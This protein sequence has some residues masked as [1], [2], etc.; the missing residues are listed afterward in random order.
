MS[1]ETWRARA[2]STGGIAVRLY[3]PTRKQLL[4]LSRAAANS[5]YCPY[6]KFHVGAA[7]LANG[8]FYTGSNI[9]NASY[10]LTICAERSAI[11]RAIVSGEKQI[12][13]IAVSC[14]DADP[15]A[16]A[17]YRMPCGA[18]RQVIA[19]FA[20]SELIVLVDG[21][22]DFAV[23]DLL[24]SPFLLSSAADRPS[25]PSIPSELVSKNPKPRLCV[26]ID[27][28]IADSDPL[29]R[30]IITEVTKG[31]VQLEYGDVKNFNYW[32]CSDRNA[33]QLDRSDWDKVHTIFSERV[34]DVEP[35]PKA[36]PALRRLGEVF[37][38]HLVTSRKYAAR[39]GTVQWLSDNGFPEN[40]RLHFLEWREKHLALG[41]FFA[42]VEDEL[43]QAVSFAHAGIHSFLY[44]HPWNASLEADSLLHRLPSWDEIQNQLLAMASE[45][46]R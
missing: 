13:A 41:R 32:Q 1:L 29:M 45:I 16:A 26:D 24:P 21:V 39:E 2:R 15:T 12:D 35:Y 7:V 31:R 11:F 19:E 14:P 3:A 23:G 17:T 25:V 5:A 18:C 30:R 27:N 9:E 28:V 6:S 38:I 8:Q 20:S 46:G 37:D 36:Q 43:E 4:E 10:G 22:G 44:A 40:L 33:E 34:R 42:A